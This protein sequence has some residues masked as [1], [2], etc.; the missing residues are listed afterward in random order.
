MVIDRDVLF[1][2]QEEEEEQG[3]QDEACDAVGIPGWDRV[4]QLAKVLLDLQGLSVTASQALHIQKLYKN[5]LDY[6]RQPLVFRPTP[7][8]AFQGEIC[9]VKDSPCGPHWCRGHE[10]VNSDFLLNQ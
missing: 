5:L 6:D 1:C 4:D 10:E 7:P 8:K 2:P 9:K 3:P